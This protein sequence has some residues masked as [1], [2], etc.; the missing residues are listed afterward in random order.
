MMDGPDGQTDAFTIAKTRLT[1][2]VVAR[3][4]NSG[5]VF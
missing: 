3:K 4:N 2:I 5:L 1:Y